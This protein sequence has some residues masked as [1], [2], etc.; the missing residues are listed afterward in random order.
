MDLET[1]TQVTLT[2]ALDSRQSGSRSQSQPPAILAPNLCAAL[3]KLPNL[4]ALHCLIGKLPGKHSTVK[5]GSTC[6]IN[7]IYCYYYSVGGTMPLSSPPPHTFVSI[8]PP[9][10]AHQITIKVMLATSPL[11]HWCWQP[12]RGEGPTPAVPSPV[13]PARGQ[14]CLGH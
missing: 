13:S 9:L 5:A 4:S 2:K 14:H 12:W 1:L 10:V 11:Q 3:S 6:S 8:S 7:N